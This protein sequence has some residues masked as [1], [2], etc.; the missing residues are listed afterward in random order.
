MDMAT[1]IAY[2]LFVPVFDTIFSAIDCAAPLSSINF[3]NNEPSIKTPK[4]L[5]IKS[6]NPVIY[7]AFVPINESKNGK[8]FVKMTI[9]DAKGPI[10]K[11]E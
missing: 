6:A 10:T 1:K 7:D 5:T 2:G 8:L 3:A 9:I 4:K 11:I